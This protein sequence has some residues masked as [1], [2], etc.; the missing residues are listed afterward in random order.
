M[1]IFFS[2][3][4]L[5]RLIMVTSNSDIALTKYMH[6]WNYQ[7][8]KPLKLIK[9]LIDCK[10]SLLMYPLVNYYSS[11]ISAFFLGSTRI[12]STTASNTVS[13][14][15]T[16][17]SIG[18]EIWSEVFALQ[19]EWNEAEVHCDAIGGNEDGKRTSWGRNSGTT[20]IWFA[21]RF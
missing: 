19:K 3:V 11:E 8:S 21:C 15:R 9:N 13:R 10:A 17:D 16:G 20:E 7:L 12:S 1:S 18:S 5:L 14:R 6:K 2:R 4:R